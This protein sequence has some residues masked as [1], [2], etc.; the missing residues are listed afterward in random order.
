MDFHAIKALEEELGHRLLDRDGKKL[1]VT[2]AG[3]HLL[4]YVEKVLS[5]MSEARGA[6]DQPDRHERRLA[7]RCS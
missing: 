6:L 1:Q 4:H 5:I 7:F 3:E 2:P